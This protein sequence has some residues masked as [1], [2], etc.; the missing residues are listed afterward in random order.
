MLTTIDRYIL[1]LFTG[2][3]IS[4]LLVFL[5][6]YLSID[7]LSMTVRYPEVSMK[8][9]ARYYLYASPDLL[10]QFFSVASLFGTL[11]TLTHLSK[12]SELIALFAMGMS[13]V[14][15]VQP[16][17]FFVLLLSALSFWL[18][19]QYLP[20]INQLKNYTFYYEIKNRP[21]QFVS[22]KTNRI[23]YRSKNT[24]FNLKTL[25]APLNQ[26]SGLTL[27][28][29]SDEW[30]L[31]QMITA[32]Q[33][34]LDGK[35]WHL[36]NGSVTVF[37]Q[38]SSF[39]LTQDFAKKTLFMDEAV[40]DIQSTV[41]SADMLSVRELGRY[42]EKNKSAGL[43]M[44]NFEVGFFAKFAT[45][46]NA[47]VLTLLGIP[48]GVSRGR[49]GGAM[50]NIG[51]SLLFVFSYWTLNNTSLTMGYHGYLPPL[52]AAFAPG[53]LTTCLSIWLIIRKKL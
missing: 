35:K 7:A 5:V 3:F 14:R 27:Y 8:V 33:I 34:E 43:N 42:I 39:P 13:F 53:F 10:Y 38:D 28:D 6:L 1:K 45:A 48:F 47:L 26:A 11:F 16:I 36:Q 46:M 24:I 37:T 49:A 12:N 44:T 4:G 31:L 25:N 23:W 50:K 22:I 30:E 52:V 2:F 20:K 17:V 32:D 21:N 41:N 18:S 19:N 9:F 15:V 51:L 40:E 29:F